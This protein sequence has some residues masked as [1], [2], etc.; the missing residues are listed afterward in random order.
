M[1]HSNISSKSGADP[2]ILVR[3]GRGFFFKGM[4]V[5]AALWPQWVQGNTLVG[6]QGEKPPEAPEF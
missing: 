1:E 3:R 4:G 5:G 2:G 6:A